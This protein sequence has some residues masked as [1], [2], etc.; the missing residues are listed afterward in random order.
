VLQGN[1]PDKQ[2]YGPGTCAFISKRTD[3]E[4]RADAEWVLTPDQLWLYDN[5]WMADMLF[6]GR[7]DRTHI[8]LYRA[9]PY[10]CRIQDRDGART[11]K[12]HDRGFRGKAMTAKG[13]ARDVLLLRAEYPATVG[14]QDE[15]RLMV[16]EP[17]QKKALASNSSEALSAKITLRSDGIDVDCRTTKEFSRL[18]QAQ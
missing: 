18:H 6:L 8:K 12:A 10:E 11:L 15:L 7:E 2:K 16:T 14:L 3:E 13:Q 1:T 4:F 9:S 17:G 5:N